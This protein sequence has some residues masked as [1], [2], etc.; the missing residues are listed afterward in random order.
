MNYFFTLEGIEGAGKSTVKAFFE[1]FFKTYRLPYLITR[2]PGGTVI[3]EKIRKIL[4]EEHQELM[5]EDTELLLYFASRAQHLHRVILPVLKQGTNVVSDRFTEATFAYQCGGRGI[6]WEKVAILEQLV[7]QEVRP[8][9]VFLLDVPVEIG[10]SRIRKRGTLDRIEQET[11][12]FFEKVRAAYLTMAKRFA[13]RFC[14]LDAT[15]PLKELKR[16]I[17]QHLTTLFKV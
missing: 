14:V 10:L 7:Q 4:L 5:V 1:E 12:W 8:D 13:D 2:E 6:A 16:K 11:V 3:A 17:F 9:K 15:S